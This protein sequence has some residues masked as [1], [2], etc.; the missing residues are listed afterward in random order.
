MGDL[1]STEPNQALERNGEESKG[2]EE[3]KTALELKEITR[4]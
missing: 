4:R 2:P 1:G 3:W